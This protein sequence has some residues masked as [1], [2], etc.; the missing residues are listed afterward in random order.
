[1]ATK[2]DIT[3]NLPAEHYESLLEVFAKGFKHAKI[4][5]ETRK[6]LLAWWNAEREII[7]EEMDKLYR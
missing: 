7:G 2:Q 3:I 6:E 4:K 1:M 5:S